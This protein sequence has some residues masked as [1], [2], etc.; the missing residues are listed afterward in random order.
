M[1]T[2]ANSNFN[3][4]IKEIQKLVNINYGVTCT[5]K[6]LNGEKDFNYRLITKKGKAYYLK[7]YPKN[8]DLNFI[9][10]Q[11]KLL[12]H[13]SKRTG[14]KTPKNLLSKSGSN[15][16]IFRDK[17]GFI[18]YFR[19]NSWIEGRLWSKI[20]P[21]PNNL[22][23]EL[24]KEAG[25]ITK[26]LKNFKSDFVN[27]EMQ[28]DISNSLWTKQYLKF[29]KRSSE[30]KIIKSFQNK[31]EKELTKFKK[32]RKSFIH[33]DVN[34]NNI[35]VSNSLYTPEIDGI[36][37]LGD[38]INTQIINDVAVTCVYAM[39]KCENP[40][41]AGVNVV[42]GYNSV[43]KLEEDEIEFLYL[44]IAMRLIISITKS[45]INKI[46]NK[47]N[48]YLLISE[49]E[50]IK[51]IKK[52]DTVNQELATYSF[53]NACG[54]T[55]HPNENK[56]NKWSK[57][58][59]FK[60]ADIF[61]SIKKK[62]FF[63]ID[64][65]V[66]SNW[67]EN[68]LIGKNIDLFENKI[69][70]LKKLKSNSIIAGGYLEPRILYNSNNYSRPGNNGIENRTI[71]LG[72]DFW[73]NKNTPIHAFIDGVVVVKTNNNSK[74]GYGGLIILEHKVKN[75]KFYS[76]YGHLCNVKR[77]KIKI[78]DKIKKGSEIGIV[79]D[80]NVNG[81][82]APHLH[83]QLMLNL[84]DF[85]NDFPGVCYYS[86]KSIWSSICPD[87]NKIFKS[88]NLNTNN[89]DSNEV[90]ISL[91]KKY[92]GKNLSLSYNKP[93]KIVRGKDQYLI[94]DNGRKY[95]D[96]VNNIAHVGHE[97][98]NVVKAGQKQMAILNTNTRYLHPNLIRLSEEILKTFPKKLS[99]IYFVNSGSEANEL[100]IRLMKNYT[101]QNDIIVFEG[102]YHGSTNSTIEISNYKYMGKGGSGES[103]HV[104]SIP[105]P[106]VFRGKYTGLESS[107]DY[108]NEV[109][110]K[111]DKIKSKGK[112]IAGMIIEPIISCGG[113][114]ELPN[115]FLKNTYK[116]IKKN[117][118]L[119]VSDEIQTGFGRVGEK[120]WGFQLHDVIPDIVTLGKPMGNG[121]PIGA[122]ICTKEIADKFNNGMEFFSSF[123]GN[124]VSCSIALSVLKELKKNKLQ[125]NAEIIGNY[126]KS[127]LK[128]VSKEFPIISN[129]RG[130]GLFL[131][132]E[133]TSNKLNPLPDQTNYLVNRMKEYGIL[134]SSDGID[135]NV[136]KI[137]PPLVFNK[138]NTDTLIYF[139]RKVLKEDPMNIKL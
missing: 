13:L 105:M 36:I 125:K 32:L 19:I 66:S 126:I 132:F 4:S 104:H 24:G 89:Q 56:F 100:A 57:N 86:E 106:D 121:H 39:M 87:P 26:K 78:G 51:L 103:K 28:W 58:R 38:S 27:A 30:K 130:K 124:P 118:G 53:R 110:K 122:V 64:L 136:I 69:N 99:T 94:D 75:L 67:L 18:R 7:I 131:G 31:F 1:S 25:I 55:A 17:K 46:E 119:L 22:R 48:K 63:N 137:K 135:K 134:M 91:R 54:Y 81:N 33:N 47:E 97:N 5:L 41:E 73:I 77:L 133:L 44:V 93:I 40:L 108:V 9:I 74:K 65:S 2:K 129:V 34:D 15:Y 88:K 71:H 111:V 115:N 102:G 114:I 59:V 21:I 20:N 23:F 79:G 72:I 123:G 85:K 127:E 96:T 113:Q 107:K 62:N 109:A 60:I 11:T 49:D 80:Y 61:P 70:L 52:W 10:F 8:T 45:S 29:I 95:L 12:N 83:F 43:F 3:F 98:E 128:K 68:K 6:K 120:F 90:L 50:A 101:G 14:S 116:I 92:L 35:I 112:S 42:K 117:K 76:L 139:L 138:D 16:S 82:W 84:L 37:D